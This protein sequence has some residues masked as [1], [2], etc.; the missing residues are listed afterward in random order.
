MSKSEGCENHA[1]ESW[2][3][4]GVN[5]YPTA[6]HA[7][8]PTMTPLVYTHTPTQELREKENAVL[9]STVYFTGIN[10]TSKNY[11]FIDFVLDLILILSTI[12]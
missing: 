4:K 7:V 8:L 5:H 2:E 12:P 11:Y 1:M 9:Y 3:E 10:H 6:E